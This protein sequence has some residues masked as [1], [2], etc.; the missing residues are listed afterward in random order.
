MTHGNE[1]VTAEHILK[2]CKIEHVVHFDPLA[3]ILNTCLY[4][5]KKSDYTTKSN[6]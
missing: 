5:F 2:A 1:K 4:I 3:M 6:S